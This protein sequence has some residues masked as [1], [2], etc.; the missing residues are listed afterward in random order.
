M[1]GLGFRFQQFGATPPKQIQHYEAAGSGFAI[2][3]DGYFVTNNHVV[4]NA[5]KV[6]V[7]FDDGTQKTAKIVGTDERTDLAVL[8]VDGLTNQPFVKLADTPPRVGDWVMAIGN[9][10]GLGGTVTQGVVSAEGRD[11]GGSSY[12]DFLQ[13]DAAVNRGNSG[14]PTFNLKGEVIGVNT[15]IYSPN[16]GSVGIAFDIPASIVKQV[17]DQ[18]IKSGKV[19]RGALGVEIQDLTPDLASSMGLNNTHG[20]V[21]TQPEQGSAAAKAGVQSGDVIT[22]VNGKQVTDALDL[23]R[24]IASN[25]PGT[26]VALTVFRNGKQMQISVTLE[27][28][29]AQAGQHPAQPAG[30]TQSS[31]GLTLVPNSHGPGVVVQGVDPN[32][33][34]ATR[35]FAVG[36]VIL[37]VNHQQVSTGQQVEQQLQAVKSSGRSAVL[38]KVQRNGQVRYV[39]LPLAG[40]SNDNSAQ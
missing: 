4:Q 2:S 36:D 23:S 5:D 3:P 31:V 30:P 1:V 10:F 15:E 29:P 17:T 37:E 20:A 9:P 26:S 12:G 40:G 38:I 32:G 22:A 33:V 7:V 27:T 19:T 16:G 6:T 28:L 13:I 21:V 18:L 25:P 34:A 8:K 39:G 35:G 11:I 24:T 14:G